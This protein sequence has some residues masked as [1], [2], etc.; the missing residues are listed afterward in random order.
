MH[1]SAQDEELTTLK[2]INE[3]IKDA[4]WYV[5]F[6]AKFVGL[7]GNRMCR[8]QDFIGLG[9]EGKGIVLYCLMM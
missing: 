5:Q 1:R 8:E 3:N 4:M 2:P 9:C 7:E 6:C